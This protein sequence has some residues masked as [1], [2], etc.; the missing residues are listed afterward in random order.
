MFMTKTA[1]TGRFIGLG[2]IPE[3][4]LKAK[5]IKKWHQAIEVI[6]AGHGKLEV[7]LTLYNA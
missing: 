2:P 4:L 6:Y 3:F 5:A 1:Q 7:V